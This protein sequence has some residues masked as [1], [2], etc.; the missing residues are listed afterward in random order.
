MVLADRRPLTFAQGEYHETRPPP[1]APCATP[2]GMEPHTESADRLRMRLSLVDRYILREIAQVW[3]AVT[4]VLVLILASN[5]LIHLLGKVVEGELS[6]DAVLPFFLI[7]LTAYFVTL[8]PLGLFLALLLGFGRLYAESEMAAL[9][10]CGIGLARL[11][12]PVALLGLVGAAITAGLTIYA[13]PWAERASGEIAARVAAE[14]D[15]AGLAPGRFN[16]AGSGAVLFAESRNDDGALEE[17]FVVLDREGERTRIVRAGSARE[18]VDDASGRRFLEFRAGQRI[19]L[20]TG[21]PKVRAIEFERHG[22]YLPREEVRAGGPGVDGMSMR[23][24]LAHGG[25]K[26]MAELQWRVSLPVACFLLAM[27]A[28]PLSHTTPRKGRYGKV[29]TGLLLYLVYSN[30]LVFA[31]ELLEEGSLPPAIGMWWTHGLVGLAVLALI[32]QRVGWRWA[33]AVLVPGREAGR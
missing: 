7:R 32:A 3:V 20:E 18:R 17:V 31:Q 9:G 33:L 22:I 24:L 30:L 21:S 16:R 8:I 13:S 4:A 10:A 25:R 29:A 12:R 28:L 5:S 2:G 15:F 19:A 27:A 11:F 26:H 1:R 23:E 6:G 14:S